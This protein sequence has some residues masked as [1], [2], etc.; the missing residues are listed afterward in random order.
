M[1]RK[2]SGHTLYSI[3]PD[4]FPGDKPSEIADFFDTDKFP[5]K[6]GV[7]TWANGFI[8]MALVADGVKPSGVYTVLKDQTGAVDRAFA[9]MDKIK[10]DPLFIGLQDLNLLN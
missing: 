1:R 6:R 5:G 3:D 4:A 7:H 9:M 2:S 8:Q 10:D